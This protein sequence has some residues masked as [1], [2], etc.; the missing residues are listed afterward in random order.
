MIVL[1][2]STIELT[3]SERMELSQ[4]RDGAAEPTMDGARG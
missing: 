3:E 2:K 4:R 1:M